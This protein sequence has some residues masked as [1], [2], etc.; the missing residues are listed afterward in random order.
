MRRSMCA[1]YCTADK[2]QSLST[3]RSQRTI[4]RASSPAV[5]AKRS[6]NGSSKRRRSTFS[7]IFLLRT[8]ELDDLAPLVDFSSYELSE[9]GGG[10]C[11]YRATEVGKSRFQFGIGEASVDRAVELFNNFRRRTLGRRDAVERSRLVARHEFRHR[12]YVG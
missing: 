9:A 11:Q 2:D 1:K 6:S 5:T 3:L 10:A 7:L 12:R 8:R 4:H